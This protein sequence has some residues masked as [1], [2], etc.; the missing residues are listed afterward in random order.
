MDILFI[1]RNNISGILIKLRHM[2][3]FNAHQ[4]TEGILLF[5]FLSLEKF[6]EKNMSY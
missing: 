4:R 6:T 1:L 5:I 2:Q 3:N